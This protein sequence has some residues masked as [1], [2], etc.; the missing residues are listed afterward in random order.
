VAIY[1][2][3][4]PMALHVGDI[5]GHPLGQ[6]RA[7]EFP[8][9]WA[10]ALRE[11]VFTPD[12]DE[13]GD[14]PR[15]L[16]LW[17]VTNAISALMPQVLTNDARG[18]ARTTW[19]A[20]NTAANG[21]VPDE[22]L[23]VECVRGGLVA[24][25]TARN[26]KAARRGQRPPIDVD[27]LA[28]V[29]GDFR[30]G[31]LLYE[32]CDL[33]V[34]PGAPLAREGFAVLPQLLA[35]ALVSSNWQV[36]Y[37]AWDR[38]QEE[39][40]PG[41]AFGWRRTAGRSNGAEMVSWPPHVYVSKNGTRYPWS[42]TL[43]LSAQTL[44]FDPSPRI[45]VHVGIRRWARS[46][47]FDAER[48]I[49]VH[50]LSPSPWADHTAPFGIASIKWLK[51][52]SGTDGYLGWNDD[53]APTLARLTTQDRLPAPRDLARDPLAYLEPPASDH[54]PD[55]T[56]VAGVAFRY[57]LG[58]NC[59]HAVGDGVSARDR[60]RLFTQLQPALG[61]IA[62]P[63]QSYNQLKPATRKRPGEEALTRVDTA[64]LAAATSGHLDLTL[65]F[66]SAAIRADLMDA[67]SRALD[68]TW[69]GA[70]LAPAGLTE[71]I[72]HVEQKGPLTVTVRVEPVGALGSELTTDPAI[73]SR[74][75]RVAAAAATRRT[76]A[77]GRFDSRSIPGATRLACIE[78]ADAPSFS[79]DTDPKKA[80]KAGAWDARVLTQNVTPPKPL[81][82]GPGYESEDSRRN[83][84]R[85]SVRDLLIRQTGLITPPETLGLPE[86]PLRDIT[87]VGLWVVRRNGDA[88]VILPLAVA[89]I[90]DEPFVR[91]RLPHASE[92]TPMRQALLALGDTAAERVYAAPQVQEFFSDVI[93]EVSDGSD[94]AVFTLAQNMRGLCK[95]LTNDNL[96]Q[97]ILAFN[98][99]SPIP[100]GHLKGIRHLRLRT[101]LR[102][103]T[104]Q[105]FAHGDTIGETTVGHAAWLWE[106]AD[107]PR[108]FYSTPGKPNSAGKGSPHGSR[109]EAHLTKYGMRVDTLADVWNPRLLEIT[110][111][112]LHPG[113]NAASWAAIPHQHRY[114]CAHYADPLALPA[115]LHFANKIGEYLLP[116]SELERFEDV[117]G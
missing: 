104:S 100:A 4:Q 16:P 78:M 84:V 93:E 19:L 96:Q 89:R 92:W 8:A 75:D 20:W 43:C 7:Y 116:R 61:E 37:T 83:R 68:L 113:D 32:D 13:A 114:I 56:P 24:A 28:A 44:P 49:G 25:A 77:F 33:R 106:D 14:E 50:L 67:T 58:E 27:A 90:P 101:N 102:N 15:G 69:T 64:H 66:D 6:Y 2:K 85:S 45:H 38:E 36:D 23:L 47:V 30:P 40:V 107:H 86:A 52:R 97:D 72:E 87:T 42:Y 73:T 21:P 57:G 18:L 54:N 35:I 3:L 11:E 71:A 17:A 80:V 26:T 22:N 10:Q 31:D 98:P 39:A 105:V 82:R 115:E 53:L 95:G 62:L 55:A 91:V 110:A 65:L 79:L 103:E 70:E 112:V 94:T 9:A 117:Y 1:D 99:D 48:A 46:P 60:W 111:A 41:C 108:L 74:K 5:S 63:V 81:G 88:R 34:T 76:E 51:S 109:L 29:L 12:D 59:K